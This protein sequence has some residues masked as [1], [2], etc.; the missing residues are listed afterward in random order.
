MLGFRGHARPQLAHAGVIGF[1]VAKGFRRRGIAGAMFADLIRWAEASGR[2]SR[3]ECDVFSTNIAALS[4]LGS[5]GFARE[6]TM[7]RAIEVDGALI[8]NHLMARIW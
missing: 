6:G 4:L 3:I 1:G 2:L 8:D 7:R 5:L